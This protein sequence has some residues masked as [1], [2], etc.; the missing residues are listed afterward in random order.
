[1]PSMMRYSS[2]GLPCFVAEFLPLKRNIR[3]L[4]ARRNAYLAAEL[5]IS[6]MKSESL[7]MRDAGVSTFDLKGRIPR[8]NSKSL[9]AKARKV[10]IRLMC[11]INVLWTGIAPHG[12]RLTIPQH[13]C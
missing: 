8:P 9:N 13:R 2:K 6:S 10:V 7:R 1:M 5:G 3:S 11:H 4:L 12:V